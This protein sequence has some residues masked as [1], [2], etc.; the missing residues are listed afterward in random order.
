MRLSFETLYEIPPDWNNDSIDFFPIRLDA[1][2][3]RGRSDEI[4]LIN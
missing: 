3:Q 4:Y 2:G 1:R